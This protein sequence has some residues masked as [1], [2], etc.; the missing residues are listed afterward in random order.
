MSSQTNIDSYFSLKPLYVGW[1]AAS[2]LC[3]EITLKYNFKSCVDRWCP[4]LGHRL[5]IVMGFE[6]DGLYLS[7]SSWVEIETKYTSA[8]ETGG[9]VD[10][11]ELKFNHSMQHVVVFNM[12]SNR[13]RNQ[14]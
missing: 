2:T 7:S 3:L 12:F 4:L 9:C 1:W 13:N 10:H 11:F 6:T 8:Y 14:N 5:T